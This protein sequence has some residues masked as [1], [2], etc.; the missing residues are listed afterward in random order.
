MGILDGIVEWIA[1]QVMNILD[2]ITT[3]VLGALGCS[4]DTFL[5]YFPAAETMYQVFL[6]LGI[7]L[8]LLNWVWQLFKNYF[9]GAGIEAEDPIK[10]SIRSFLFIF[11]TFYAKDI[12]DLL[13]KI[14]GTPYNWI[15]TED[16]PPLKFADFNSVV[17]VI[18]G[19]CANG[20]VAI[21]ALILVLI[22][23]WNYIKLLFEAAER[24]ILL[25]VLVYTAP[26][27]FSMGAS[28]STGNIFK[29]WCRMLG[30]QFFLLL[31]NAWCLRLFTSMVGTFLA[32]PLSLYE[33]RTKMKLRK[34]LIPFLV[35]TACLVLFCSMP[36]F[37]AELTE[38]DV[39]AAVASQGKEA[40]TGNVF[41]WFLCAIAFLKV[42]QKIDSFLASLGINVGNTGGNM[43]AEL[44]IAGRSLTG[45]MRS[46][47][48]GG[49]HKASSP[50]SAAVAGS[51]LSGGLA[52]AV[53]RQ[54]QREAVNSATGYTEHSSIGN[55]LYQSSLNK[56][57]DFA[58]QVISNIAQGNYGQVGSIKG[59]D[60]QK[61]FTSYMGINPG[62]G[63]SYDNVEIGGGRI[64]GTET[65]SS[66]N[67]DFALY[68]ADQYAAPTQ[69]SYSTVQS[70]DGSTWYKQYAQDTVEKTPYT[71]GSGKVAYNE[72]IVQKLPPAPQRKERM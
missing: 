18:L 56:G 43:M 45:S 63:S 6:A 70:V 37:A 23:A 9:M 40:V 53:G 55:M 51:F 10:L 32:N 28:Q 50:G 60:A 14:S 12:V 30:G 21:I 49:Y 69:G 71:S 68:H 42:S 41:V 19:V 5:R 57:G 64:T 62:G 3:S 67:R 13:L 59:A 17:T 46:H 36:V 61:A 52:G 20:A 27:A 58:N 72:S 39:E 47:G 48:G 1:E 54:V 66:G 2:L 35:L 11:L 33:R 26:A 31:M 34:K 22:L 16:L 38:A 8:I 4:M 24:Y 25:G 44:L 29:S 7:G 15:L 65:G